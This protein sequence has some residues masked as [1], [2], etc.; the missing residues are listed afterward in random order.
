[1]KYDGVEFVCANHLLSTYVFSGRMVMAFTISK[2]T[3]MWLFG[4]F[5]SFHE[6]TSNPTIIW[7]SEL[8]TNME[9]TP[10]TRSCM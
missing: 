9:T 8:V 7:N 10:L 4:Y 2:V 5:C 1:M 6:N 3:I